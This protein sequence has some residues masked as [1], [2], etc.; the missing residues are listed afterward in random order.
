MDS[1][2]I[3]TDSPAYGGG[4]GMRIQPLTQIAAGDTANTSR[5]ILP[6]YLG[7]HV[8]RRRFDRVIIA[9][10]R[11]WEADGGAC[12]KNLLILSSLKRY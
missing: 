4:E 8:D 5:L 2:P 6:N 10:L 7:T 11:V 1:H 12:L 3:S 9:P